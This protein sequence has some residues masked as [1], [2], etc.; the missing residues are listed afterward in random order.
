HP[1]YKFENTVANGEFLI[2]TT[3]MGAS[4]ALRE[5][6]WDPALMWKWADPLVDKA[7]HSIYAEVFTVFGGLTLA[8]IGLY[9][10]WRSR[11]A[12]MSSAMTTAGWAILVMVVVTALAQWPVFSAHAA[13]GALVRSLSTVDKAV[14]PPS[15]TIPTGQCT[16]PDK[17]S[18]VDSRSPAIRASD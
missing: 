12:R 2:A 16:L 4:N 6:A 5:R 10:I 13:D 11:Q 14:G 3:V 7:T 18:C 17:A 1:D 8:V 9:L 15:Q